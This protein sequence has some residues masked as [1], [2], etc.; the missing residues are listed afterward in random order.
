VRNPRNPEKIPEE[1]MN[2]EKREWDPNARGVDRWRNK[3]NS[4]IT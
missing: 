1:I 4:N 3:E 2:W